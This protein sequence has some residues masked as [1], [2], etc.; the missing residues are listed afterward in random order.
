MTDL[1]A[2]DVDAFLARLGVE[3]EPPSVDALVR[4]HRAL[5][6]RVPYETTWIHLGER[7]GVDRLASLRRIA[8]QQRGGYCFQI[9]GAFSLLLEALGYVVTLHIGGVH[10]ADGPSLEAMSNHLVLQVQGL[11]ADGCPDGS[12]YVDA[13]LGDALYEPLPLVA[14]TYQQGPF[15]FGLATSQASFADWQFHHHPAGSFAGM[16]FRSEPAVI[17]EFAARNE[18]LSTSPGSVF[19]QTVTVQRRNATGVDVMRGQVLQ[20]VESSVVA[21]RTLASESEWFDA[22]ADVF[23]LPLAD[24]PTADRHGLWTR[25]HTAHEAWLA[26]HG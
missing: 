21:E 12:W 7:W 15:K 19:V 23:S 2:A 1:A 16:A 22:L 26:A 14:G 9:N 13:G 6:E 25:V 11:P 5:L 8:Y 10:R 3:R 20:R 4:L 18:F 17:G 24:V